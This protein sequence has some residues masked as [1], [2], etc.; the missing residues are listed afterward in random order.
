MGL[1]RRTPGIDPQEYAA[2]VEVVSLY[3][4]AAEAL[5]EDWQRRLSWGLV[6]DDLA[7]IYEDLEVSNQ[8]I[9]D[10]LAAA[11][12]WRPQGASLRAYRAFFIIGLEALATRTTAGLLAATAPLSD[13]QQDWE[14]WANT[15]LE[16]TEQPHS[17]ARR[18]A[19][20]YMSPQYA[21]I[22]G[23]KGVEV[24]AAEVAA[25]QAMNRLVALQRLMVL[26]GSCDNPL[27]DTGGRI[28]V[29][30]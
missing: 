21:E 2:G 29:A 6:P 8:A 20:L 28:R 7:D 3:D 27:L 30:D 25:D 5:S 17:S 24:L 19:E 12:A 4:A 16:L 10:A 26:E 22:A 14:G 1:F 23:Y 9:R 13:Q 15:M 11:Q 18:A